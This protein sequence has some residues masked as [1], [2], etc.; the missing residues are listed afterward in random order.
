MTI[1][2][3][4]ASGGK[5]IASI[6]IVVMMAIYLGI[7]AFFCNKLISG[8]VPVNSP[9]GKISIAAFGVAIGFIMGILIMLLKPFLCLSGRLEGISVG[10]VL[11]IIAI[12]LVVIGAVSMTIVSKSSTTVPTEKAD[13]KTKR[14]NS[15]VHTIYN[16]SLTYVGIAAGLFYAA[17]L[18]VSMYGINSVVGATAGAV[19]LLFGSLILP[20]IFV[21]VVGTMVIIKYKKSFPDDKWKQNPVC[22]KYTPSSEDSGFDSALKTA[23]T[24]NK[25]GDFTKTAPFKAVFGLTVGS[26]ILTLVA[27]IIPLVIKR[28]II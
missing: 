2:N 3:S 16:H 28:F 27:I 4:I 10:L 12:I 6:V 23:G 13:E 5:K 1:I 19:K 21:M 22:T 20:A 18:V 25:L 24:D 26:G 9:L 11:S 15:G 17:A 7:A 14:I 8:C